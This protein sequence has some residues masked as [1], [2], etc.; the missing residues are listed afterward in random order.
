M[1]S[2]RIDSYRS[3]EDLLLVE[4]D[5]DRIGFIQTKCNC[6]K[7]IP[8]VFKPVIRIKTGLHKL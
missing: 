3:I 2:E 4:I 7:F 5:P 6:L 8:I 1:D